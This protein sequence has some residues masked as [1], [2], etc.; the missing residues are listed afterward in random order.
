MSFTKDAGS[1][2]IWLLST[3]SRGR[4]TKLPIPSG[5]DAR[6]LLDNSSEV[7][8]VSS[9]ML[10]GKSVSWF[11]SRFNSVRVVRLPKSAGSCWRPF[12]ARA[13]VRRAVNDRDRSGR[14][15]S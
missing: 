6:K 9:Q 11:F 3:T 5:S 13:R 8:A 14:L 7:R 15:E 10:G 1:S 4:F 2:L 12:D